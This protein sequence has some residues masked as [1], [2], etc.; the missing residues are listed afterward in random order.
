MSLWFVSTA[1][2]PDMLREAPLSSFQQAAL[3]SSVQ[4]GFV[5]GALVSAALGLADRYDPRMVFAASAIGAALANASLLILEPGGVF[6]IAA[7]FATG[8]LLAGVYP[9]GEHVGAP[10]LGYALIDEIDVG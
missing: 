2:L 7:R 5:L 9:V 3:S 4:A 10:Q 6:A 8:A 1:I